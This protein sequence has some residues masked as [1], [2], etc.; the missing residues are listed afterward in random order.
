MKEPLRTGVGVG[1]TSGIITISSATKF[2]FT[3]TFFFA[4]L[5]FANSGYCAER[6]AHCVTGRTEQAFAVALGSLGI[7][8]RELGF[9]KVWDRDAFRLPRQEHCLA[10]PMYAIELGDKLL[11]GVQRQ[12]ALETLAAITEVPCRRRARE[13]DGKRG[14][15]SP[16]YAEAPWCG[17]GGEYKSAEQALQRLSELRDL[18]SAQY[19]AAL[20]GVARQD[21]A[22][23]L[24]F[25]FSHV[26][27]ERNVLREI[28]RSGARE[29]SLAAILRE[30]DGRLFAEEYMNAA[31]LAGLES[32]SL[33]SLISYA[34][35]VVDVAGQLA[36]QQLPVENANEWLERGIQIGTSG[37]DVYTNENVWLIIDPGGDDVYE[38]HAGYASV[39]IDRPLSLIIDKGGN[40]IYRS[41]GCCGAGCG[42]LGVSVALDRGGDDVYQGDSMCQGCGIGGV[43]ILMDCQ[44]NDSYTADRY[45]QG[46]AF[47]GLGGL[48]DL[49]GRD[50]YDV[51]WCGQG[52]GGARGYGVLIDEGG[53][54]LYT[55]GRKYPDFGRYETRFVSLS[56]GVGNGMRPCASGGIGA[57]VDKSGNDCYIADVFG[58]GAGYWFGL[59]ILLDARGHDTYHLYEYG[60][61]AGVHMA[62]G[63]LCDGEG[64]DVYTLHGG[65]GQGAEHDFSVGLLRDYAGNDQYHGNVT[66]Q[67]GAINNGVAFLIDDSGDDW[68]GSWSR[69]AHGYGEWAERRDFG[70]LGFLVDVGGNDYYGGVE[71]NAFVDVRGLQGVCVDYPDATNVSTVATRALKPTGVRA[72]F[73]NCRPLSLD[74]GPRSLDP[75]GIHLEQLFRTAIDTPDNGAKHVGR[76]A[77][78]KHLKQEGPVIVPF[79]ATKLE[80]PCMPGAFTIQDLILSWGSNAVPALVRAHAATTNQQA[81][82]ALVYFLG[83]IRDPRARPA[84]ESEL[85]DERNRSV[86]LWALGNC[87][88]TQAV[89]I[90]R[91]YLEE[92]PQQMTRV[93]SA[94]IMRKLG[95]EK[96]VDMLVRT[97][98]S[99]MD[100]NV[101]CAAAEA[102]SELGLPACKAI[103]NEWGAFS[104]NAKIF[105]LSLLAENTN[106]HSAEVLRQ[107]ASDTNEFVA[108]DATRLLYHKDKELYKEIIKELPDDIRWLFRAKQAL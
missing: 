98:G 88:V 76:A 60:Q 52:Y 81:R 28:I 25:T 106:F 9:D 101:R 66:V 38:G 103:T 32:L 89:D 30:V 34:Y 51:A 17:R 107:H 18:I 41:A 90:A 42:V 39:S 15:R 54:D 74:A 86:A 53:N 69:I 1:L 75:N 80:H 87:G 71:R 56:Q 37:P 43:G 16:G 6:A 59:G 12:D 65:I 95:D 47:F 105:A 72:R 92:S 79:L 22:D 94:G 64:N 100:W 2:S 13:H 96:D 93:R 70:A 55:A 44:G 10:D 49:D 84:A 40:D 8:R 83:L 104:A 19:N 14:T 29:E 7:A 23:A 57:L 77:A 61:G 26:K 50:T 67:G 82:R 48:V 27:E 5:C 20:G 21:L 36:E 102:L 11:A 46:A 4:V 91:H 63:I 62:C 58:Q 35:E 3:L 68:Y 24:L 85:S 99:D 73:E 45:A 31:M 97:L 108:A 78:V 33:T